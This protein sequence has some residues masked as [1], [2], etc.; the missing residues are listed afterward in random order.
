MMLKRMCGLG[1]MFGGL[2]MTQPVHAQNLEGSARV[3]QGLIVCERFEVRPGEE[4]WAIGDV[5]IRARGEV[6]IDGVLRV[7]QRPAS[8]ISA[9]QRPVTPY[10]RTEPTSRD[11]PKLLIQSQVG[12]R[13]TG[14]VQGADGVPGLLGVPTVQNCMQA[15]GAGGDLELRAPVMFVA[16]LVVGGTGG[17]SGPNAKAARGGDIRVFGSCYSPPATNQMDGKG[18]RRATGLYGGDAGKHLGDRS[19]SHDYPAGAGGQ[20]GSVYM[21]PGKDRPASAVEYPL[22]GL[23]SSLLGQGGSSGQIGA[24]VTGGAGG[25]FSEDKGAI[26]VPLGAGSAGL[27]GTNGT[28]GNGAGGKPG[29]KGTALHPDGQKGGDGQHGT[30][31][32]GGGGQGGGHGGHNC[33]RGPGGLGGSGGSGGSGSGGNGASG[34]K[35]G[36]GYEDSKTGSYLGRGG[37]GGNGGAAG[38]GAGGHGGDGGHGGAPNGLGGRGGRQGRAWSGHPGHGGPGGQGLGGSA[39]SGW[40]GVAGK[41]FAGDKGLG[42]SFGGPCNE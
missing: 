10:G 30:H 2:L 20:G 13:I 37:Q 14:V 7:A 21:M 1:A 27:A 18:R 28:G 6:R 15:G 35:G 12:I 4:V 32:M 25:P 22:T 17:D 26:T 38:S 39:L 8:Q 5:E 3:L 33:P 40:G 42:G 31:G 16:G 19:L 34:G 41:S 11:A 23:T 24:L 9:S 29:A 36:D